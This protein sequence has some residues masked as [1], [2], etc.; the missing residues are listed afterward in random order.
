MCHVSYIG[1][2]LSCADEAELGLGIRS[3]SARWEGLALTIAVLA[4]RTI[5]VPCY[6]YGEC[7]TIDHSSSI[8]LGTSA[9]VR[10]FEPYRWRPCGVTWDSVPEQSWQYSCGEPPP[11][12]NLNS[13]QDLAS[14]PQ[15]DLALAIAVT[16]ARHSMVWHA[17][18]PSQARWVHESPGTRITGGPILSPISLS[19]THTQMLS[20][21]AQP[22]TRITGWAGDPIYDIEDEVCS[23]SPGLGAV[24]LGAPS[25][26][27][28]LKPP[29]RL[30]ELLDRIGSRGGHARCPRSSSGG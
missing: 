12:A 7:Q 4:A 10:Q 2:A 5:A 9:V 3:P 6:C 18:E 19:L 22:V 28:L 27:R 16:K 1:A 25:I 30:K 23:R 17:P 8:E 15:H 11:Y 13:K 14:A 26:H 24:M 21:S 29:Y 20:L